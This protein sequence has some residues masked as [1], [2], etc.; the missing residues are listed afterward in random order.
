MFFL[1]DAAGSQPVFCRASGLLE[2]ITPPD[3]LKLAGEFHVEPDATPSVR[4]RSLC[5]VVAPVIPN[6]SS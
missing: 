6:R 5:F 4:A 3:S 2:Q 1:S